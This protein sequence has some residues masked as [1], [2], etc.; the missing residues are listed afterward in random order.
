M[1]AAEARTYAIEDHTETASARTGEVGL[2]P[3]VRVVDGRLMY[4]AAWIDFESPQ[5][6]KPPS[7]TD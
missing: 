6:P 5:D 4:S 3:G 2:G 7:A 1:G